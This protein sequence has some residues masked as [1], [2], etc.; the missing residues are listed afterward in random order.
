MS[1]RVIPSIRFRSFAVPLP[2]LRTVKRRVLITSVGASLVVATAAWMFLSLTVS[3]VEDLG[4]FSFPG[5]AGSTGLSANSSGTVVGSA[6]LGAPNYGDRAIRSVRGGLPQALGLPSEAFDPLEPIIRYAHASAT[7][8]AENGVTVGYATRAINPYFII[9]RAVV[10]NDAGSLTYLPEPV[11]NGSGSAF[12]GSR[13]RGVSPAGAYAVGY[14]YGGQAEAFGVRWTL[15]GGVPTILVPLAGDVQ[16]DAFYV[17]DMGVSVGISYTLGVRLRAVRWSA[18][19][20]PTELRP[21]VVAGGQ[22][23]AVGQSVANGIDSD[24]SAVGYSQVGSRTYAVRW[25]VS[26]VA[27]DISP[28]GVTFAA[29]YGT[30]GAGM[31]LMQTCSPTACGTGVALDAQLVP[32]TG[33]LASNGGLSPSTDGVAYVTG[34]TGNNHNMARWRVAS[35]TVSNAPPTVSVTNATLAGNEGSAVTVTA[36]AT[37]PDG[38]APLTYNWDLFDGTTHSASTS[39]TGSLT[40][41]PPDN[42]FYTVSVTATD[43]ANATSPTAATTT[44]RV[45]NVAPT[46]SFS[47]AP[48]SGRVVVG[49]PVGLSFTGITDP[50]GIDIAAGIA[51]RFSCTGAA[52][53]TASTSCPTANTGTLSVAGTLTDKDAG[54]TS[55]GPTAVIIDPAPTSMTVSPVA[56]QYSDQVTLAATLAS[57]AGPGVASAPAGSVQFYVNGTPSGSPVAVVAAGA[58]TRT[59]AITQPAGSYA[60]T[61]QFTSTNT[62][63]SSSALSSS[64]ALTVTAENA[65]AT[66][67]ATNPEAIKVASVGGTS[68]SFTLQASVAETQP[69]LATGTALAGDINKAPV[70]MTLAPVGPGSSVTSSACSAGAVGA[71]Y[72]IKT[73]ACTFANVPVNTYAV[74]VQ[75]GT[76]SGT[77]FYVGSTEDALTVYDPSLGFA[78]GG[79]TFAWPSTGERTTFGFAMRYGR[80]GT[81][82]SGSV[83]VVRHLANGTIYRLKS[84]TL[85]G[86][87]I[88]ATTSSYG[89]A[90]FSGKGTYVQPGWTSPVGNYNWTVYV[91]DRDEPGTGPDKFW[92]QVTGG[93]AGTGLFLP[94]TA[95]ANARGLTGGNIMAPHR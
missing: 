63:Y 46:G 48:A 7:S 95:A 65:T 26:G 85:E 34:W 38:P 75:V 27:T 30:N 91:E 67:L 84:S 90:T 4:S 93:N 58:V 51:Q 49:N 40:F 92:V 44:V 28:A 69:D 41:T 66:Y 24:G 43:G 60:I 81:N 83:I 19:G 89:Y 56:G 20:V 78:S 45:A 79:G 74:Q 36:T 3:A 55:Y 31:T 76:I 17:N 25:D 13:A 80:N 21:L 39:A 86:L 57:T 82:P 9:E 37:D 12:F 87:A 50:S 59:L 11:R 72:L 16:S 47:V 2:A 62:N 33:G 22:V 42:G 18:D 54:A 64:A 32:L 6:Q 94:S 14:F 23:A 73:Y 53:F 77:S 68:P 5:A 8:V 15:S 61:A 88:S 10:W 35:T 29:A 71:G 1:G 52:P 70:S